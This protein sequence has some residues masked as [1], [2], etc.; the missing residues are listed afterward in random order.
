MSGAQ[1]LE[2][3]NSSRGGTGK[4]KGTKRTSDISEKSAQD[5]ARKAMRGDLTELKFGLKMIS[6]AWMPRHREEGAAEDGGGPSTRKLATGPTVLAQETL[7][8][9]DHLRDVVRTLIPTPPLSRVK[10]ACCASQ[11][12]CMAI[13]SRF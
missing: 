2:P 5:N 12:L 11:V 4:G 6:Q 8:L 7:G 9:L 3:G 1:G 10:G 13:K